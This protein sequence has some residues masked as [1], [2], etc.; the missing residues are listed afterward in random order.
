MTVA[1]TPL[2]R[3]PE[4]HRPP[5]GIL[6]TVIAFLAIAVLIA[7]V[8]HEHTFGSSASPTVLGSGTPSAEERTLPPFTGVVMG[9][10]CNV[11]VLTGSPQHVVVSADDNLLR[12]VRTTVHG[13]A[14][15][16]STPGDYA[17]VTPMHVAITVPHVVRLRLS[18]T[19]AID[20]TGSTPTLDATLDG[21]GALRLSGLV[22]RDVRATLSGT[23]AIAVTATRSLDAAVPGT[24]EITYS[25]FPEH[26]T[27]S[28]TGAGAVVIGP[29]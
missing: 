8:A 22:A 20:A 19:G 21:T 16:I 14:L 11:T 2:P 29:R 25:G 3:R 5:A 10:T 26:V 7:V 4:T 27:Q 18:G 24:G 12:T 1:P 9:G 6:L 28:V 17:A 15:T 13:G 23:G